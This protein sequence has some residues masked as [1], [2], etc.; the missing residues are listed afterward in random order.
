MKKKRILALTL[1]LCMSLMLAACGGT[2]KKKATADASANGTTVDSGTDVSDQLYVFV[3][4][5]TKLEYMQ[6]HKA[7]FEAA[8]AAHHAGCLFCAVFRRRS[9]AEMIRYRNGGAH[10]PAPRRRKGE[11]IH[12]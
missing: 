2:S 6:K 7:G 3:A 8:C 10:R 4:G 11:S 1:A 5:Q 12:V 9:R